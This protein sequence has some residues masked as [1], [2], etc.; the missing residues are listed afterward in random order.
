MELANYLASNVP[1]FSICLV[2]I[3]LAIRNLRTKK[4]E[5]VYFLEFTAIVLVLSVVV[6]IEGYATSHGLPIL[7]TFFTSLG[8][9]LRPI[10]LYI[11]ILLSNLEDKYKKK[12]CLLMLIPLGIN[13]I[14]H[15]FPLFFN[16]P[17]LSTV[18]FSYHIDELTGKAVFD[19]G[20][21]LNFTSHFVSA[22]YLVVLIIL[23]LLKF[24]GKH[25]RDAIMLFLCAII[26]SATVITEV[27]TER[28]DL[29]NIVSEICALID[30]VF[31]V[32]I[33][34]SRDALT[35]LYDRKTYYEDVSSFKKEINGV[36]QI[37]MNQLKYINDNF[38][39]DAG[40]VALKEVA[41]IFESSTNPINMCPYRL[42]GDEF[43]ILMFKGKKEELDKVV[44]TIKEKMKESKYSVAIG[45]YFIEK[46][47]EVTFEDALKKSEDLMYLDKGRYYQETGHDRRR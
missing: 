25:R 29:L 38:G 34:S 2:M 26:T 1:I 45:H 20:T 36:I 17:G 30:Y 16:V 41:K 11:F 37:D 42:S 47:D 35:G 18:V 33:N 3:Y 7:G 9:I 8:Y 4:K 12:F 44:E 13:F 6:T 15:L 46:S 23:S 28:N 27:V 14:I 39:H 32:S 21:I 5:G 19:R 43:T 10:L 40:D 31:I 22:F 24:Q